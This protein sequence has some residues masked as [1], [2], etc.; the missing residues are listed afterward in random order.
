MDVQIYNSRKHVSAPV[1][2]CSCVSAGSSKGERHA[3]R[4]TEKKEEHEHFETYLFR[5][6]FFI[7]SKDDA[8]DEDAMTL[9]IE[10]FS[11]WR[12]H[13]SDDANT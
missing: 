3:E 4:S 10:Y 6:A 11:L 7:F 9:V 2:A 12:Q 8:A 13:T 5:L 1:V